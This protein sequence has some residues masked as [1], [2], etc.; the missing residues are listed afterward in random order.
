MTPR[1]PLDPRLLESLSAYLDGLLEGAKRAALERRLDRD[2]VLRRELDELR[3]VRVSLRSLPDMDPP[4][5]LTLTPAQA[6]VS[7]RRPAA[8]SPRMMAWGSALASLAFVGVAFMDMYSRGFLL[9]GTATYAPAPMALQA[10]EARPPDGIA[11]PESASEKAA[12]PTARAAAENIID[13]NSTEP[14]ETGT[15]SWMSATPG[16]GIS[17]GASADGCG[18][19]PGDTAQDTER[20]EVPLDAGHDSRKPSFSLP[21][22][23]AAAP[24]LEGFFGLAAVLLGA[25]AVFIRRRR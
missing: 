19:R 14:T 15:G 7:A 8:F 6:G 11:Q 13:R 25:G 9:R 23:P 18:G 24:Y 10:F 5:P 17:A 16:E 21:G 20:C 22:L 12:E 3:A 2:E 4:R 1:T